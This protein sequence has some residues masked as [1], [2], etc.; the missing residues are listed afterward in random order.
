VLTIASPIFA[1]VRQP[2]AGGWTDTQ[3]A[4]IVGFVHRS[5]IFTRRIGDFE[6]ARGRIRFETA[7]RN[8]F[9]QENGV[10]F[11]YLAP[12]YKNAEGKSADLQTIAQVLAHEMSH[13]ET[14]FGEAGLNSNNAPDENAAGAAG[15]CDEARAYALEYLVQREI[16]ATEP[17]IA[18]VTKE[19]EAAARRALDALSG[20][21]DEAE[22][23]DAATLTMLDWAANWTNEESQGGYFQYYQNEWLRVSAP[24]RNIVSRRVKLTCDDSGRITQVEFEDAQ[25][26]RRIA[27]IDPPITR[28]QKGTG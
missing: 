13:F 12:R 26:G 4:E 28:H 1:D 11:V 14:C 17:H 20:S 23:L 27:I 8:Y 6:R 19:Q 10:P 22:Q 5:A 3:L 24:G 16:N 2:V 7:D 9:W 21:M 18:W 15:V 25:E